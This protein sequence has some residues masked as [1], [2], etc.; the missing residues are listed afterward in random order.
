MSSDILTVEIDYE[1][2]DKLVT[3]NLKSL[4]EC[5]END[6]ELRKNGEG[7]AIFEIDKDKDLKLL[8]KHIKAF[9][10]VIKY[11]GEI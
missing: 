11:Y 4:L 3:A 5:L 1:Q 8:K 2:A 6:Y 9:K 7:M 10:T